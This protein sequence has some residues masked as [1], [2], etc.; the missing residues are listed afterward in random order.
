MASVSESDEY[1]IADTTGRFTQVVKDGRRLTDVTWIPGRIVL[2]NKR[3]VLVGNSGKRM[4]PL[5]RISKL[6]GRYDVNQMVAEVPAYLS[7]QFDNDVV[8]VAAEEQDEFE[9]DCFRAMLDQREVLVRH[10]AVEGGVVRNTEWEKA[11]LKI[12]SDGLNVATVTGTFIRID[13]DDISAIDT[14]ERT[15]ADDNRT[16]VETEH[17]EDSTS[18]QTYLSAT[19]GR[20]GILASFLQ[21]GIAETETGIDLDAT[22]SEVLMALYSGVEPFDIPDFLGM[23]VD[24]VE[25]I[26]ADLIELDLLEEVRKRREV[27]LNARGRNIASE[28]MNEQ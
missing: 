14:S 4:I 2:S 25:A 15:I 7:L 6:E 20:N 17:T 12:E 27:T 13:L 19:D 23:E 18:V 21:T 22:E 1:R 10:P 3:I 8:L 9:I 5:H 11:R 16:V 26:L 28:A 24:T